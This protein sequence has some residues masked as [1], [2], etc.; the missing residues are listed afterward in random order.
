MAASMPGMEKSNTGV[1]APAELAPTG[2]LEV[3]GKAVP[4]PEQGDE[5]NYLRN[6]G[7]V[8]AWS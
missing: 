4:H 3:E 5:T 1:K 7:R 8:V 6:E 2:V